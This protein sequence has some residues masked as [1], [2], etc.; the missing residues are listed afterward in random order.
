MD[1]TLLK[2]QTSAVMVAEIEA[3]MNELQEPIDKLNI[4]Q[5][6]VWVIVDFVLCECAFSYQYNRLTGEYEDWTMPLSRIPYFSKIVA[7]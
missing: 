7:E 5:D 4:E 2:K 3:L 1:L 6:E